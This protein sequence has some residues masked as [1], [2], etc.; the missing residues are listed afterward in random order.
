MFL[1]CLLLLYPQGEPF[2]LRWQFKAGDSFTA[3]TR[4]HLTQ[5]VKASGQEFK[6]DIIHTTVVKYSVVAVDADGTI[7]LDQQIESMKATNPDGSTS[8]GNNAV[9]NQLQGAIVKAKLTPKLEVKELEGYEE[10]VK[11]LAGDD[12]SIRRVVQAIL[13]EDQ[14]KQAIHQSLACVPQQQTP[15][16]TRWQRN[17]KLNLGP[18]GSINSELNYTASGMAK[19]DGKDLVKI[20]YQPVVKYLPPSADAANPELSIASGS[21]QLKEG[22]GVAYFNQQTGR[23]HSSSLRLQLSGEMTAKLQNKPVPLTFE[24]TQVIE[25]RIQNA[26]ARSQKTEGS[27]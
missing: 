23:L 20:D 5:T 15:A 27:K 19:V 21:I 1:L 16:G 18:L 10:L 4:S 26:E 11:R 7:V 17:L 24:Q 25:V 13:S 3:E 22:A 9:L 14:L 12:P 8:V 2:N 6:Q